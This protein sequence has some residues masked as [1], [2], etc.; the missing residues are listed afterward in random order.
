MMNQQNQAKILGL[1]SFLPKKVLSNADLEKLVDT[2][3][4]WITTRT[5]IKERRIASEEESAS[6]MAIKAAEAAIQNSGIDPSEIDLVLTATMTPDHYGCPSTAALIQAE[7]K[8]GHVP[9]LDLQAACTGYIYG[10]QA[11]KAFIESGLYRNILFVA[12]EKMS[13]IV[14][15]SDRSTCVLFGDGASAAVISAEGTGFKI[16][17][18]DLAADGAQAHLIEVPVG[19]QYITMRGKEVFKHAVRR[20]AHSCEQCLSTLELQHSDISWL[21]PHQA[22]GRIIDALGRHM[23]VPEEKVFSVIHK[24]G[25][26]SASSIGIA[27]DELLQQHDVASGE[28]LLLVAFGAGLTWGSAVLTKI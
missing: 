18:V 28:R 23:E 19:E 4:E 3:D 11:A 6:F 1:G 7:L 16:D 2:S 27:L 15:F 10:L 13:S 21:I 12:T 22:N 25:N 17:H 20:M 24:Y 26:T 9:A 5:G 8:I 14:D